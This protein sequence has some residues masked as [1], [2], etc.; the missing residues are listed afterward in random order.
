[1]SYKTPTSVRVA[2]WAA[3]AALITACGSLFTTMW[4]SRP[5]WAETPTPQQVTH[6]AAPIHVK[7]VVSEPIYF[8][9]GSLPPIVSEVK[10]QTMITESMTMSS[11]SA[12]IE[13]ESARHTIEKWILLI[14]I[15]IGASYAV[16]EYFNRRR[17]KRHQATLSDK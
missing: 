3:I 1:M 13:D 9:V 7:E 16:I 10:H 4:S 5:W 12:P 8:H 17:L 15:G 14:S 11:M 6:V 2:R